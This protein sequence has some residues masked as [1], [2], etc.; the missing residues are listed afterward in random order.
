MK[1]PVNQE[2]SLI[3][4]HGIK[5]L[6]KRT[7]P[8]TKLNTKWNTSEYSFDLF[9]KDIPQKID[10]KSKCDSVELLRKGLLNLL[11]KVKSQFK[12]QNKSNIY[13]QMLLHYPNIKP[14]GYYKPIGEVRL[15][16]RGTA[17]N[18]ANWLAIH[19]QQLVQ[20]EDNN[21]LLSD[22]LKI[23]LQLTES[24]LA[25]K[26]LTIAPQNPNESI[27]VSSLQQVIRSEN[28]HSDLFT[29]QIERGLF[30]AQLLFQDKQ[31]Q[32]CINLSVYSSILLIANNFD[33]LKTA[34]YFKLKYKSLFEMN[35]SFEKKYH[36]MRFE[37]LQKHT[38]HFQLKYL[39]KKTQ[40]T[41]IIFSKINNVFYRVANTFHQN[42]VGN[43]PILLSIHNSHCQAIIKCK[44]LELKGSTFCKF[45]VKSFK[46]FKGHKCHRQTCKS[47]FLFIERLDNPFE[48]ICKPPITT[49]PPT[50]T[51]RPDTTTGC[52]ATRG[53]P[54]ATDSQQHRA[55][56]LPP[57]G[58]PATT[59]RPPHPR[60]ETDVYL[61]SCIFCKKFILN[62]SCLERHRKMS[63]KLCCKY[64]RCLI[65]LKTYTGHNHDC[66]AKFCGKCLS[67]HSEKQDFCETKRRLTKRNI[68][69]KYFLQVYFENDTLFFVCTK[70][71]RPNIF[72]MFNT[73]LFT[74]YEISDNSEIKQVS[75]HQT[76]FIISNMFDILS[77]LSVN[78]YSVTLY[79]PGFCLDILLNTHDIS[80]WKLQQ[81]GAKVCFARNKS[82]QLIRCDD[83]IG[84]DPVLLASKLNNIQINPLLL[85]WPSIL[86]EFELE[87]KLVG[88]TFKSSLGSYKT[89]DLSFYEYF[90][91][92]S[93]TIES[94]QSMTKAK[95]IIT[96]LL[97]NQHIYISSLLILG[98]M[99]DDLYV[100]TCIDCNISQ[101]HPTI[102][103]KKTLA[104]ISFD[105]FLLPLIKQPQPITPSACC[106]KIWN[107]SKPEICF[108]E[109]LSEHHKSL[110]P[111]HKILSYVD[112]DGTQ[113]QINKFSADW[114]CLTC[115]V[116]IFIE[117]EFKFHC[118]KHHKMEIPK[119]KLD[120]IQNGIDKRSRFSQQIEEQYDKAKF[121]II[122]SCCI[123]KSDLPEDFVN[124]ELFYRSF[125]SKLQENICKYSRDNYKRLNFQECLP[126]ALNI[127]LCSYFRSFDKNVQGLQIDIKSAY[128]K[129]LQLKRFQ[130]PLS[131]KHK[132]H[133]VGVEASR[134]FRQISEQDQ[135]FGFVKCLVCAP[136]TDYL[137]Y[138]PFKNKKGELFYTH[139]KICLENCLSCNH[140]IYDRSFVVET[141]LT[142]IIFMKRIGYEILNCFEII[143]FDSSFNSQL[144]KLSTRLQQLRTNS[145]PLIKYFSKKLAL[146]GIGKFGLNCNKMLA[147]DSKLLS[148]FTELCFE[149]Q[150][151]KQ[152]NIEFI[153]PNCMVTK[154]K[155]STY[156]ENAK[157]SASQNCSSHIFGLVSAI[158]RQEIYLF[159]LFC[160]RTE[161]LNVLRIDTDSLTIMFENCL[162][163]QK[164]FEFISE[165]EFDYQIQGQNIQQ[166]LNLSRASRFIV[167]GDGHCTLKTPGFSISLEDRKQ[168][169][170]FG[171]NKNMKTKFPNCVNKSTSSYL[172]F[173][174]A[175]NI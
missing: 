137:P 121:F 168:L 118:S 50:T 99:I 136:K 96:Q 26:G 30:D 27:V 7:K 113:F 93:N 154:N 91:R 47:C 9:L 20:S 141:Y 45:C 77:L 140:T 54:A 6:G 101:Q 165:S 94:I 163:K 75:R 100:D 110:Y 107:S 53:P 175:F 116:F 80:D 19:M 150:N 135:N 125:Y 83:I 155:K 58:R 56:R 69:D 95:F 40:R 87:D 84:S 159:Y 71:S 23:K 120:L 14:R 70:L 170:C 39:A 68:E 81:R 132:F 131:A 153:G 127:E 104:S 109:T 103:D 86:N 73:N 97:F 59:T 156:F 82:F 148:S 43:I 36:L 98:K 160:L 35:H 61:A 16:G 166:M 167:R 41:I 74:T 37:D 111:N 164:I 65:C 117:G 42:N 90:Q 174:R 17:E 145:N 12:R 8:D 173:Q 85:L 29:S 112:F 21:F 92:F 1:W 76:H 106:G 151:A 49:R 139:C 11:A 144:A 22:Q 46:Y 105:L 51:T 115:Q 48:T 33:S 44:D 138:Y 64:K 114:V 10:D 72:H 162:A 52:P 143:Y 129:V 172:L 66:M 63:R 88:F 79:C 119:K 31:N 149:L 146:T 102:Y 24:F 62:E 124:T 34:K 108:S 2:Q 18:L 60:L 15:F 147:R 171:L 38:L 122:P 5:V 25:V 89:S 4:S 152:T 123:L 55:G 128:L 3:S 13:I 126:S 57:P 134:F 67:N 130:L 157:L 161:N 142:E 32:M 169:Q 78:L 133:F 28:L 158:V